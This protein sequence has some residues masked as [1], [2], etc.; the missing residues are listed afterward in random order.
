MMQTYCPCGYSG[1]RGKGSWWNKGDGILMAQQVGAKLWH[2]NNFS[3]NYPGFRTLA[4]DND[5]ARTW[6]SFKTYDYIFPVSYTHLDVYKRQSLRW[7]CAPW[8]SVR[9]LV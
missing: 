5:D 7:A 9:R 2:M 3:G 4:L 6:P 8:R 1:T